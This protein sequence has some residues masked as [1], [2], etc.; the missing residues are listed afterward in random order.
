MNGGGAIPMRL[1]FAANVKLAA[2]GED[3]LAELHNDMTLYC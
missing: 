1:Q 2:L 3:I